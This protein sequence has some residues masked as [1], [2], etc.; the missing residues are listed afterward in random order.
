MTPAE[1]NSGGSWAEMSP[2]MYADISRLSQFVADMS[3]AK[4]NPSA[5]QI[6]SSDEQVR[7]WG[8]AGNG[9]G[10]IWVQ[11]FSLEGKPIDEVRSAMPLR[12][13]VQLVMT[14]LPMGIYTVQPYNTWTGEYL[15]AETVECPDTDCSISLPEFKADIALKI[16]KKE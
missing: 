14:G 7:A 12:S 1:W 4:W 5:L 11:D 13:N 16:T 8:F 15:V 2:E 10:L 9:G 3:L 6:T